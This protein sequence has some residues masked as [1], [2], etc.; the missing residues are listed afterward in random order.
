MVAGDDARLLEPAEAVPARCRR[1]AD[2]LGEGDLGDAAVPLHLGEDAQISGVELVA[3]H[4]RP[5]AVN[6]IAAH[7]YQTRRRGHRRRT[8][9]RG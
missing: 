6:G 7:P 5:M 9:R 4:G 8:R 3:V 2:A 1:Q